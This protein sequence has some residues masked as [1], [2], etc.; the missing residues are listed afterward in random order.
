MAFDENTN[1]L[2]TP[3]A[4]TARSVKQRWNDRVYVMDFGADPTGSTAN[5]HTALGAAITEAQSRNRS[6][7]VLP[8]GQF[9]LG[10][11][12]SI[13][14]LDPKKLRIVGDGQSTRILKSSGTGDWFQIGAAG[15]SRTSGVIFEDMLFEAGPPTMTAGS[16]FFL[17]NTTGIQFI[18]CPLR[19]VTTAFSFGIGGATGDV[20]YTLLDGCDVWPIASS[21]LPVIRLGGGGILKINGGSRHNGPNPPPQGLTYIQQT[22]TAG[23][24]GNWDGLY[25]YDQFFEDFH[26]YVDVTG[27][28]ISNL[29]WAG[30]QVDGF[31]VGFDT[32]NMPSGSLC[33]HW[34]I[35]GVEFNSGD[36]PVS[37]ANGSGEARGLLL[38]GCEFG[39]NSLGPLVGSGA[40][41]S[42]TNN[43][44]ENCSAGVETIRFGGTGVITG[45]H[46]M[47][48]VSAAASV[49]VN[50]TTS[51]PTHR[52]YANNVWDGALADHSGTI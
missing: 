47:L 31:A 11:T 5:F 15:G 26:K 20:V 6:V 23:T 1:F 28:G 4:T 3:S 43:I 10:G 16:V 52:A 30:G 32:S 29:T 44:F 13:I 21:A 51:N 39:S 36:R 48:G 41:A 37:W 18:N 35:E 33:R 50:W 17:R 38:N 8:P 42:I 25:V 22:N 7:V 19:N 45:N 9:Q 49:G 34:V 40:R 2:T 27:A 14:N 12:V 46:S 24:T